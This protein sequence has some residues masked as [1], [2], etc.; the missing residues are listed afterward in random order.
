MC[1]ECNSVMELGANNIFWQLLME[2]FI[3]DV[4]ASFTPAATSETPVSCM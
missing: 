3:K 4:L 2:V 1:Y